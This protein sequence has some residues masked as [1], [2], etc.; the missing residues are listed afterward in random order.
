MT[1]IFI[2]KLLKIF[3]LIFNIFIIT[4]S[5][6][7]SISSN[8]TNFYKSQYD[9]KQNF[10]WISLHRSIGSPDIIYLPKNENNCSKLSKSLSKINDN[11]YYCQCPLNAPIF[12]SENNK[13]IDRLDSDCNN[14]IIFNISNDVDSKYIPVFNLP[15]KGNEMVDGKNVRLKENEIFILNNNNFCE[16]IT[17]ESL[18]STNNWKIFDTNIFKFI[19]DKDYMKIIWNG[20]PKDARMIEGSIVKIK[21][22]CPNSTK[23]EYCLSFRI[24]GYQFSGITDIDLDNFNS[25][26]LTVIIII[27]LAIAL[28]LVTF[29]GIILWLICWKIKKTEIISTFQLQFL[30]HIK[31]EKERTAADIAKYRAAL[32]ASQHNDINGQNHCYNTF[33]DKNNDITLMY[34]NNNN[35]SNLNNNNQIVQ[36]KRKLYFSTEFFEP[37]MMANPPE[38]AEQ[39]L[40]ELRKMIESAKKRIK[41][42][43]HV[44]SLF[45]IPEEPLNFE[46]ELQEIITN[47]KEDVISSSNTNS[48]KS[49]KSTDSGRESMKDS[50]S[51]NDS[52]TNSPVLKKK[53]ITTKNVTKY[54]D[55][56]STG[57]GIK[58]FKKIVKPSLS[59]SKNVAN[60]IG[61]FEQKKEEINIKKNINEKVFI[62]NDINNSE[63]ISISP[64]KAVSKIPKPSDKSIAIS[65]K[66]SQRKLIPME[67]VTIENKPSK[68]VVD[69]MIPS[70]T[71]NKIK[72]LNNGND[73]NNPQSS[74]IPG[75]FLTN[76]PV[77]C[78]HNS[79]SIISTGSEA[80]RKKS[81]PRKSK[82]PSVICRENLREQSLRETANNVKTATKI[83]SNGV[84]ETNM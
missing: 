30:Q 65:P 25:L 27:I 67:S 62:N 28:I 41:A 31:Q 10:T 73:K 82:K 26:R 63:K 56:P 16:I 12:N 52:P 19:I 77:K 40:V 39:F 43:K 7:I 69:E 50:C 18:D 33:D 35:Q 84:I 60:L 72:N 66:L 15:K 20:L 24:Q 47:I 5:I 61:T 45:S 9:D 54:N 42:Q 22:H 38:I 23:N 53:E 32:A 55:I 70:T 49:T 48:P 80:M 29:I 51:S 17:V 71:L 2:F 59:N 14:E 57:N 81:L 3:F 74:K 64:T 76:S 4:S 36:H 34:K 75:L 46:D 83:N 37:H 78:R 11:I 44:P 21:L 8:L 68:N 13:C 79:Y 58:N 1:R 6:P